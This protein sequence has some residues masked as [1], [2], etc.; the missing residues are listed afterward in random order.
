MALPLVHHP[1]FDARFDPAHRFPMGKFTRLAQILVEDGLVGPGGW[2]VP[3]PADADLLSRAHDEAYVAA[4][5]NQA[6]P[7]ELEK[8]IGFVAVLMGAGNAAG[9]YVVTERMLDMF[10]S[11]RGPGGRA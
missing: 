7:P 10:R 3:E 8:A 11:S 5:L 4:V 1:A 9:G 2:H 6:V